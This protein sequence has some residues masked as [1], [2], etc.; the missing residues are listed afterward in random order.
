VEG[1]C[2]GV[3]RNQLQ[4]RVLPAPPGAPG[5]AMGTPPPP[6]I[7]SAHSKQAQQRPPRG[8]SMA[9]RDTSSSRTPPCRASANTPSAQYALTAAARTD[10]KVGQCDGKVGQGATVPAGRT[11]RQ[12]PDATAWLKGAPGDEGQ[13]RRRRCPPE[14]GAGPCPSSYFSVPIVYDLPLPVERRGRARLKILPGRAHESGR[15]VLSPPG[16]GG[17][18]RRLGS[19]AAASPAELAGRRSRSGQCKCSVACPPVWP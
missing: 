18:S 10:A 5:L 4:R 8:T 11:S 13:Q 1:E 16:E 3:P 14:C 9:A 6:R 17:G 19:A 2:G 12:T 7:P 15:H